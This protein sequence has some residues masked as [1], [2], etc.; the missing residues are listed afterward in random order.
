MTHNSQIMI[1]G[2]THL[3]SSFRYLALGFIIL[4]IVDAVLGL[5]SGR[6]YKKSSKMF[7]LFALISSHIQLV[8]GLLLYFLGAKGFQLMMNAEGVMKD[9]TMRFFAVE[10]ILTMIIAITLVTVGY[11]KAK[12]QEEAK[13]KYR[14]V[15]IFFS[16]ALVFIF[17]MIPWPFLKPFGTWI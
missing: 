4:A 12:R 3:H 13:R 1:T 14:T 16:I 11:S 10:H 2:L 15:L 9:A 8:V 17:I 7:A 5:S 6:S